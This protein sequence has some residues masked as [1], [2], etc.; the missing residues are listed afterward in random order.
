M[1]KPQCHTTDIEMMDTTGTDILPQKRGDSS[2]NVVQQ[3]QKSL[4]IHPGGKTI[5][6]KQQKLS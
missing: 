2:T 5:D 3:K 4:S 6:W 1:P